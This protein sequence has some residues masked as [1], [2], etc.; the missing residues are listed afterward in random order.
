MSGD[1]EAAVLRKKLRE[2]LED[3]EAQA[4]QLR[5]ANR[6]LAEARRFLRRAEVFAIGEDVSQW[7]KDNPFP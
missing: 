3:N 4:K 1:D 7:L 2:A 5:K 6:A